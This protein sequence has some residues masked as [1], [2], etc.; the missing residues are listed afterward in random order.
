[1]L[2]PEEDECYEPDM[3]PYDQYEDQYERRQDP[4]LKPY[5]PRHEPYEPRDERYEDDGGEYVEDKY[6]P[7]YEHENYQPKKEQRNNEPYQTTLPKPNRSN[8]TS[9]FYD[10]LY[11]SSQLENFTQEENQKRSS[12]VN[13]Q[14]KNNND[15]RETLPKNEKIN[16]QQIHE[17]NVPLN[18][19]NNNYFFIEKQSTSA[20][21]KTNIRDV[22]KSEFVNQSFLDQKRNCPNMHEKR[23]N[24]QIDVQRLPPSRVR[25]DSNDPNDDIIRIM[26]K[27]DQIGIT[28]KAK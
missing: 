7:S 15:A 26:R 6:Q 21:G 19:Q 8:I 13:D 24:Q 11:N 3:P 2:E 4:R 14:Y 23:G 12:R 10:D 22:A 9:Q 27:F 18:S 25:N 20:A 17:Q 5:E 16:R 1:V 28:D